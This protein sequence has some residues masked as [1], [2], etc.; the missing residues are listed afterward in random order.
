M[1]LFQQYIEETDGIVNDTYNSQ[2]STPTRPGQ[3]YSSPLLSPVSTPDDLNNQQLDMDSASEI[4][5]QLKE[6]Q[7]ISKHL[8]EQLNSVNTKLDILVQ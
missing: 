5:Q 4:S 7:H 1:Y 3:N 2:T 6:L 8:Q